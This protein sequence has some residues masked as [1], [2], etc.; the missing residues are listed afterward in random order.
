MPVE[1]FELVGREARKQGGI[2]SENGEYTGQDSGTTAANS[3]ASAII[4]LFVRIAQH[5]ASFSD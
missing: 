1:I 3:G 2:A 4:F 5:S